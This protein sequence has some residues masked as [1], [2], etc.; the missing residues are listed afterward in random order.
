MN[1]RWGSRARRGFLKRLTMI[2]GATMAATLP[3]S[4]RSAQR[5][6]PYPAP[7]FDFLPWYTRRQGYRSLKQSSYDPTG[8][9]ID[10]WPIE[11]GQST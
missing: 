2:G 4:I 7:T 3:S 11:P 10:R 1:E 6:E 8:G 5:S 9:N